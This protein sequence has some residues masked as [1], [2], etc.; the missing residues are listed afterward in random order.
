MYYIGI[1]LGGTGIKAGLVDEHLHILHAGSVPTGAQR[2]YSEIIKDMADLALHVAQEAGVDITKD[3]ASIG[4]G[5]PG[6]CDSKNGILIY[7]NNINFLNVPMREEMNKYIDLP[8]Y[9]GN[10]ANVAALGEFMALEGEGI[11]D[12]I[13]IT[14]GTGIGGGIIING[15]IYEG[16]NGAGAEIGH[17]QVNM[18]D[19]E[20]CTCGRKGCWEAYGSV[21]A[22]IRETRRAVEQHPDSEM[23][24][25]VKSQN[26]KI[27]GRTAFD[28][29]KA[30]RDPLAQ[31][32]VDQYIRAVAE[33]IVS[34]I[35]IFQPQVLVIG[36]A[37][38]KEG[39]YLLNPIKAWVEQHRYSRNVAQT[40]LRIAKLGNDAGI[41]GAAYLGRQ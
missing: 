32:V 21:T 2:H 1:D 17:F 30:G 20:A 14:L 4:I 9:I 35:N 10:D 15:K 12:M 24:K 33:G 31:Q 11:E 23:A 18:F 3:V 39:D 16:F 28:L 6:T 41:I 37:I 25:Y 8:V 13:A 7:S 26:G 38:S 34:V 19:G 36:G 29:A 22:L 27:S 5:S 40:E